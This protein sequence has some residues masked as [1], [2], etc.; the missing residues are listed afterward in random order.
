MQHLLS[1]NSFEHEAH[2]VPAVCPFAG[3]SKRRT[4]KHNPESLWESLYKGTS[5]QTIPTS[6]E[7][8]K[9]QI[10]PDRWIWWQCSAVH[11][12]L[13]QKDCKRMYSP[14]N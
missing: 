11:K 13:E 3:C 14:A 7:G 6:F 9:P 5:A 8:S 2:D 12:Q 10:Y 4:A 1:P